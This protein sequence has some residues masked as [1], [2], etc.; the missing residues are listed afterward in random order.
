[1]AIDNAKQLQ[2][3]QGY[4]AISAKQQLREYESKASR[5]RVNTL[6]LA[7]RLEGPALRN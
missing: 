7:L 6:L 1:M 5:S 2:L 4:E 3:L